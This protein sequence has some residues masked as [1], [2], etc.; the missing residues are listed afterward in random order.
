MH[1]W[2]SLNLKQ[3]WITFCQLQ[4]KP[5]LAYLWT[6][7]NF[8]FPTAWLKQPFFFQITSVSLLVFYYILLYLVYYYLVYRTLNRTSINFSS[9]HSLG[10]R[11]S[12]RHKKR[13]E[14]NC[15]MLNCVLIFLKNL[16]FSVS[17]IQLSMCKHKLWCIVNPTLQKALSNL[18]MLSAKV[19][20][21]Q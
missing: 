12:I 9:D 16:S 20:M 3:I 10:I 13:K 1:L 21:C 14:L 2:L 15:T 18:K 7:L 11:R 8:F 4:Y 5:H 19:W 17:K 6:Q